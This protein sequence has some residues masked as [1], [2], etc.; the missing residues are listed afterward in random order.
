MYTILIYA[1][2]PDIIIIITII[3]HQIFSD[4]HN[5]L[6]FFPRLLFNNNNYLKQSSDNMQEPFFVLHNV[7][8]YITLSQVNTNLCG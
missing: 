7:F 5:T 4:T 2:V 1:F 8:D 3:T 6:K